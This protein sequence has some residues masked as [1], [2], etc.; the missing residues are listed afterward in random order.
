MEQ[1]LPLTPFIDGGWYWFDVVAGPRGT[2]LIEAE[3]AAQAPPARAGRLSIGITTM[4]RPDF[5]VDQLRTLGAATEVL[6]LLDAVYVVDQGTDRVADHPDFADA[7]K[8]LADRLRVIEQ[9]NIGGSGGFA[10]AMDETLRAGESDYLLL[11]DD[12]ISLDPE[13]I[14]RAVTF[15]D[16]AHRA[17]QVV[18]G[19]L[20]QHQTA[21]RLRPPEP[22]QH[23]MAAPPGRERL[24]RLVDVPDPDEDHQRDRAGAAGLHQVGRCRVRGAGQ[25]EG[26][27]DRIHAGRGRLGSEEH[28]SELQSPLN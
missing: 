14:V 7:A 12:D 18:V 23:P 1:T 21:A 6:D 2:T 17:G 26:L 22:A 28:T 11:L 8:K 27:P 16:R 13:S 10:R 9:G 20:A 19:V 3:W 24:Q 4:N 15:A 25:G 5:M